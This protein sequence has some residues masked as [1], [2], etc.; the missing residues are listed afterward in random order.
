M[1]V[2]VCL[3]TFGTPIAVALGVVLVAT[4]VLAVAGTDFYRNVRAAE[5]WLKCCVLVAVVPGSLLLVAIAVAVAG[6][7]AILAA[8]AAANNNS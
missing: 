4:C 3:I 1:A 2:A 8:I 6:L 5:P 7:L